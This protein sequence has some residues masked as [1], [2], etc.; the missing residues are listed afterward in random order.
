MGKN[1]MTI[2]KLKSSD[3]FLEISEFLLIHKVVHMPRENLVK[4]KTHCA[5][6]KL[7]TVHMEEVKARSIL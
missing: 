6:T 3:K 7:E 5:L 4:D 2:G 1:K